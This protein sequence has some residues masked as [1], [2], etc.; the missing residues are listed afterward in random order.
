MPID[1]ALWDRRGDGTTKGNGYLGLLQRPDG[2][3]SSEISIG[4]NMNGQQVEIP[5][6]VPTLNPAELRYLLSMD[7]SKDRI[8]PS[9]VQ[10]AVDFAQHRAA[11]G[12]PY[13]AQDGEQYTFLHPD[14]PRAQT[15]APGASFLTTTRDLFSPNQSFLDAVRALADGM[16]RGQK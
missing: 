4:V 11:N 14:V 15:T 9:I 12:R 7:V 8:P 3:V 1:P 5:T 10:K 16:S 13:F 6:I 2:G